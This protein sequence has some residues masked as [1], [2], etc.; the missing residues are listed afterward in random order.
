MRSIDFVTVNVFTDRR[1]AGNPL[2]VMTD[3]RGVSD[4]EMQ[5]IAAEFGYPEV[6]FVLPPEDPANTARVRIFT[7]TMEVPFAGHPNVGTACVLGSLPSLFGKPVGERMVFEEL[8]GL[9]PVELARKADGSVMAA[10]IAAP[11]PLTMYEPIDPAV[12]A[13]CCGLA[14]E[15]I[16]SATHAPA[17]ISVGL[18]F[19]VAELNDLDAL[20]RASGQR[21]ACEAADRRYPDYAGRFSVFVYVRTGERNLRSRMFAP[22]DNVAEDPATGSASGALSA[23]LVSLM[24]VSESEA[25]ISLRQGV[26]MGRP[27]EIVVEVEKQAGVVTRV[28]IEGGAVPVMEGRIRL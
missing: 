20:A 5:Q 8:A 3:A 13:A 2:A 6:T 4:G 10:R 16:S 15:D 28:V 18:P 23:Y 21:E 25:R 14:P 9:V 27:S 11:E 22:L 17:M 12:I 7:P 26:E 19:A 24:P 1:F